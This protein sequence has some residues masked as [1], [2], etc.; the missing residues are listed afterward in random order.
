[1]GDAVIDDGARSHGSAAPLQREINQ[2][3]IENHLIN[4]RIISGVWTSQ[5]LNSTLPPLILA[6]SRNFVQCVLFCFNHYHHCTGWLKKSKLLTISVF[7]VSQ[8]SVEALIR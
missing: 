1:M 2:Q 3:P 4:R 7:S 6:P 5:F 8:G